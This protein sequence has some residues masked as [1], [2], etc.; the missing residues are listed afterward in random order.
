ME[1]HSRRAQLALAMVAMVGVLL[2]THAATANQ[3]VTLS[4]DD[5][6]AVRGTWTEDPWYQCPSQGPCAP[7]VEEGCH[8]NSNPKSEK[9]CEY[10]SALHNNYECLGGQTWGQLCCRKVTD[11]LDPDCYQRAE[12]YSYWLC[13]ECT[14]CDPAEGHGSWTKCSFLC[15]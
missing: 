5:L 4:D 13:L 1:R 2:G 8:L 10:I 12:C 9:P 3:R 6:A 15:P 11:Y 7:L 14:N